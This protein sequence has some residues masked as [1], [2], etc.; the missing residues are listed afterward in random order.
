ML[1]ESVSRLQLRQGITFFQEILMPTLYHAPNSRS[2]SILVLIEEMGIAD[3]I[4]VIDVTVS[5]QDG[6][7]GP[8]PRNPHPEKKVLT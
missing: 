5:R 4:D 8:D 7:G 2:T 3:Q 6:S 1:T